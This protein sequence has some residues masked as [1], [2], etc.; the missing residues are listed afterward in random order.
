MVTT[1]A[2]RA[3]LLP[4]DV[5]ML[6]G[7]LAADDVVLHREVAGVVRPV[8]LGAEFP[9]DPA[10]LEPCLIAAA[11]PDGVVEGVYVVVDPT[12]GEVVGEVGAVGPP[13]GPEVEIGYHINVSARGRGL[14]TAAVARLVARLGADPAVRRVVARTA[15]ADRASARVL[16]KN[17]FAVCPTAEGVDPVRWER[18]LPRP[19]A[20]TPRPDRGD[21]S[22][23]RRP[24]GGC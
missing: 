24:Y 21:R 22:A 11:G 20:V 5:E 1:G 6:R 14:A 16:E 8:H 7:R 3:E 23:A 9:G 15:R 4:L 17:G 12:D 2:P 19:R 18:P 10:A 13:V